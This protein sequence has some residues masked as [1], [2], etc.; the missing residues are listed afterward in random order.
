MASQTFAFA[1]PIT[2]V[3]VSDPNIL[4]INSNQST[5]EYV[6]PVALNNVTYEFDKSL[7]SIE[8]PGLYKV[9]CDNTELFKRFGIDG[10]KNFTALEYK[11]GDYV[12]RG[13]FRTCSFSAWRE[14]DSST[15]DWKKNRITEKD[16]LAKAAEFLATNKIEAM[17]FKLGAPI[18]TSKVTDSPIMYEKAIARDVALTDQKKDD[19]K[20]QSITVM[21]PIMIGGK[22]LRTTWDDPV[23]VSITVDGRGIVSSLTATTKF[24]L[25]KRTSDVTTIADLIS[26]IK[27]GG[28]NAYYPQNGG[29]ATVKLDKVEKAFVWFSYYTKGTSDQYIST[30]LRL[31][32]TATKVP[33]NNDKNYSQIVSDY[34]IGNPSYTPYVK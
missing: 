18:V 5:D 21:Y 16:A 10:N 34:M 28:N 2:A 22:V 7:V 29:A 14:E 27:K 23:G 17:T 9:N 25:K 32:S 3:P 6:P 12:Y 31:E 11:E 1:M 8:N 13:D 24:T 19:G 15:I 26:Y 4:P 20:Y 30:G 33:Y